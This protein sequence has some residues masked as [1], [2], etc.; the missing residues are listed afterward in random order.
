MLAA[1]IGVVQGMALS[2]VLALRQSVQ[3]SGGS[4][5]AIGPGGAPVELAVPLAAAF[6]NLVI[7]E[8]ALAFSGRNGLQ[9]LSISAVRH[10][11]LKQRKRG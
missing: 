2:E 5:P 3:G 11:V 9:P 8:G 10:H 1:A 4:F 6:D 7:K